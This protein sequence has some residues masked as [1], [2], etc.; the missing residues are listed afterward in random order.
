MARTAAIAQGK[1]SKLLDQAE[2]P[3]ES[4]DYAYEHQLVQQ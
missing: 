3:E 4:L 1:V 2:T